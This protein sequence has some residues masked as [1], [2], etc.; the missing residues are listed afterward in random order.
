MSARALPPLRAAIA[1][2]LVCIFGLGA[3]LG[4]VGGT[5][6]LWNGIKTVLIAVATMLVIR[7]FEV[8]A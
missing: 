7:L 8:G 1:T 4:R 6:W 3:F 5:S 2:A